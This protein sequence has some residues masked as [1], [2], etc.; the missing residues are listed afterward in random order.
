[1]KTWTLVLFLLGV[2]LGK[3]Y[4]IPDNTLV[5]DLFTMGFQSPFD[6]LRGT[7]FPVNELPLSTGYEVGNLPEEDLI[8]KDVIP[9][10]SNSLKLSWDL[11]KTPLAF[12]VGAAM[13]ID[14]VSH[15]ISIGDDPIF[16]LEAKFSEQVVAET[17]HKFAVDL[18][19]GAEESQTIIYTYPSTSALGTSSTWYVSYTIDTV[20]KMLQVH[21]SNDETGINVD[22][23]TELATVVTALTD[24]CY[25][26]L[27]KVKTDRVKYYLNVRMGSEHLST[28]LITLS[29]P[30]SWWATVS[31]SDIIMVPRGENIGYVL[32]GGPYYSADGIK[33]ELAYSFPEESCVSV[34]N[35]EFTA[36]TSA[37]EECP[38][39]LA[40]LKG[41]VD[42]KIVTNGVGETC[43]TGC[44]WYYDES[45]CV[46]AQTPSCTLNGQDA[47]DL[48]KDDDKTEVYV[49]DV[50]VPY[51]SEVLIFMGETVKFE[52]SVSLPIPYLL[53]VDDQI[54]DLAQFGDYKSVTFKCLPNEDGT[55]TT[56]ILSLF[57]RLKCEKA[58]AKPTFS[59]TVKIEPEFPDPN[60]YYPAGTEIAFTCKEGFANGAGETI[61]G[62]ESCSAAVT[63]YPQHKCYQCTVSSV[64][65]ENKASF[66]EST[67]IPTAKATYQCDAGYSFE[68]P[69]NERNVK[70]IGCLLSSGADAP[71][72]ED[73]VGSLQK[74]RKDCPLI[75][76]DGHG[77]ILTFN[78]EVTTI[79]SVPD[80]ERY[81]LSCD[82]EDNK[83]LSFGQENLVKCDKDDGVLQTITVKGCHAPCRVD[84]LTE[85]YD[86]EYK[87]KLGD[88]YRIMGADVEY[89]PLDT[90]L[91][92]SSCKN[93][94][95]F[96]NSDVTIKELTCS[97]TH[98]DFEDG[99]F[100]DL[101][102]C[103]DVCELPSQSNMIEHFVFDKVLNDD[104]IAGYGE[105]RVTKGN[106]LPNTEVQFKCKTTGETV[107]GTKGDIFVATCGKNGDSIVLKKCYPSCQVADLPNPNMNTLVKS[108]TDN[109]ATKVAMGEH[110]DISC[111]SDGYAMAYDVSQSKLDQYAECTLKDDKAAELVLAGKETGKDWCLAVPTVSGNEG[112]MSTGSLTFSASVNLPAD[113]DT[114]AS[115]AIESVVVK[116][117]NGVVIC[118]I[119]SPDPSTH[120]FDCDHTILV[121][122]GWQHVLKNGFTL[123]AKTIK[124][125][126]R[127]LITLTEVPISGFFG[128]PPTLV[129]GDAT[130]T[131]VGAKMVSVVF[132]TTLATE[133]AA[134]TNAGSYDPL[135]TINVAE[136]DGADKKTIAAQSID[137]LVATTSYDWSGILEPL[138]EYQVKI[139]SSTTH[140]PGGD[141]LTFFKTGNAPA[142]VITDPAPSS[143][144]RTVIITL[145]GSSE[146]GTVLIKYQLSTKDEI[147]A[148]KDF[149]VNKKL[150]IPYT[151]LTPLTEYT[152]TVTVM[153]ND[154]IPSE[155]TVHKFS[156]GPTAPS[157]I[158]SGDLKVTDGAASV[159]FL[160]AE[161]FTYRLKVYEKVA[162][163]WSVEPVAVY[164]YP[165]PQE[166]D[167][168]TGNETNGNE[169]DNNEVNDDVDEGTERRR[170]N[171]D[172]VEYEFAG[173]N[174]NGVYKVVMTSEG[175]VGEVLITSDPVE[176]EFQLFACSKSTLIEGGETVSLP[177]EAEVSDYLEVDDNVVF[178]VQCPGDTVLDEKDVADKYTKVVT[179]TT[180]CTAAGWTARTACVE[181]PG[182]PV[183]DIVIGVVVAI[184]LILILVL[185]I[186]ILRKK[187]GGGG[188]TENGASQKYSPR[189]N[190]YKEKPVET[191]ADGAEL[192]D[193]V[194]EN[195][196]VTE[197]PEHEYDTAEGAPDI[198]AKEANGD[199]VSMGS[200]TAKVELGDE[201]AVDAK[202]A[203]ENAEEKV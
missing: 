108:H 119:S 115:F 57:N 60:S 87:P 170:R 52:C 34:V 157:P 107:E 12:K 89:V 130:F 194:T 33:S 18:S 146:G 94:Q 180:V 35:Y 174:P 109:D 135:Y 128:G 191:P 27:D 13:V 103:Y 187:R 79:M 93:G 168:G 8:S 138:K 190:E 24:G 188:G 116:D 155:P 123:S 156:Q 40:D 92:L 45:K 139:S 54:T 10:E 159:S 43:G 62:S 20:N 129:A 14:Q 46:A 166:V 97:E 111:S 47:Y 71:I 19:C 38:A 102:Q 44:C 175:K 42:C 74:C 37:G 2:T 202:V 167:D 160:P 80:G 29:F 172:P 161:G 22:T 16:K 144:A 56:N 184:I 50:L 120:S 136:K 127:D 78:S 66:I 198:G 36:T 182:N 149:D 122:S 117:S 199:N 99:L 82:D 98:Y 124:Y 41:A 101:I 25:L 105:D 195:P 65:A 83:R 48:S 200:Q 148:P 134:F 186:V 143:T 131:V 192:T 6:K 142:T 165:E 61:L 28:D 169:V 185:C 5:V 77:L 49:G 181:L 85:K 17:E 53:R 163:V 171:A 86:V 154:G 141:M 51:S 133:V 96:L 55:E 114:T 183:R 150:S 197:T 126:D 95:V 76:P 189:D 140:G 193:I 100:K 113:R 145:A 69:M 67:L 137:A 26:E 118:T 173:L 30:P 59:D 23:A 201:E 4:C 15:V 104:G 177:E 91:K 110:V 203:G 58:C 196:Y 106:L 72:L 179:Q 7:S 147:T 125:K 64:P 63:D 21:L 32:D 132:K 152:F 158:V 162:D 81:K 164:V 88:Q 90:P 31:K 75:A 151:D 153:T 112:Q 39:S 3:D 84:T 70:E 73:D 176:F 1:M 121:Q 9:A 178:T 11:L 68:N